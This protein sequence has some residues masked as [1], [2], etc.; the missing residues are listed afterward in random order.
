MHRGVRDKVLGR[1]RLAVV[2]EQAQ[3]A[4]V[5]ERGCTRGDAGRSAAL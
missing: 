5:L 2:P 1:G 4:R 3:R